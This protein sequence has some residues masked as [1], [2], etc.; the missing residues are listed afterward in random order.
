MIGVM[1]PYNGIFAHWFVIIFLFYF[2]YF[3]DGR[4]LNKWEFKNWK[5]I[6]KVYIFV[7]EKYTF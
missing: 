6:E 3:T 5:F 2:L 1:I 7:S 4:D